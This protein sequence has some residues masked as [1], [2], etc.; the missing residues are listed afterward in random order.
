MRTVIEEIF[1]GEK[2][3]T[4]NIVRSEKYKQMQKTADVFYRQFIDTLSEEQKNMFEEVYNQ[5]IG[6][7]AEQSNTSFI[8]GFKLGLNV[9]IE[10]FE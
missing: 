7:E 5:I 3:R 4:E 6:L 1:D 8:Q 9:A 2:Y 10:A